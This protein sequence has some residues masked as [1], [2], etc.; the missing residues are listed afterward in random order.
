MQRA[1]FQALLQCRPQPLTKINTRLLASISSV[2]DA[3]TGTTVGPFEVFDRKV[4]RMQKDAAAMREGGNRSRTVDY[5]RE[6]VADRMMDRL[7]VS[8]LS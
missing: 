3:R 7:M 4:K 1:S 6:E 2:Y 5:V 8:R